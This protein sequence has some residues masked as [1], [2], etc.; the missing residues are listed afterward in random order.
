MAGRV[1][2]QDGSPHLNT[3]KFFTDCGTPLC[4]TTIPHNKASQE[5]PTDKIL[6]CKST[7]LLPAN[8]LLQEYC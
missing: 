3:V 2:G 8:F 4:T 6:Q 5:I 1:P 7:S